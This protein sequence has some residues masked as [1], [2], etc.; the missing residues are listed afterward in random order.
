MDI[1]TGKFNLDK[2][3]TLNCMMSWSD[4]VESGRAT[5]YE[6]SAHYEYREQA[7]QEERERK[8]IV[9]QQKEKSDRELR[10]RRELA[11]KRKE[12]EDY[13]LYLVK[14]ERELEQKKTVTAEGLIY[15]GGSNH[16]QRIITSQWK[17]KQG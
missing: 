14:R 4:M 2:M 8:A 5:S 9:A 6:F 10:K 7:K 1:D 16:G 15:L 12:L 13:K 11:E 3:G 17:V